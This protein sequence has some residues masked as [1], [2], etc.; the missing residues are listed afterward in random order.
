[1]RQCVL[2][3]ILALALPAQA[4]PEGPGWQ[5]RMA[6]MDRDG[7]D[8]TSAAGAFLCGHFAMSEGD[9]AFAA[10]RFRVA[11]KA[12]PANQGIAEQALVAS[13]LA[14][15]PSADPLA[16]RIVRV[17]SGDPLARLVL[18]GSAASR[19]NWAEAAHH[20][21]A[22]SQQSV[23]AAMQPALLAWAQFGAGRKDALRALVRPRRDGDTPGGAYLYQAG[24]MADLAGRQ[25]E[26]ELLY[27]QAQADLGPDDLDLAQA[28]ASLQA[29]QGRQDDALQTLAPALAGHHGSGADLR[30]SASRLRTGIASRPVRNPADAIAGVYVSF[31]RLAREQA[32][33]E[34][35]DLLLSLALTLRPDLTIARLHAA[36][37]R[38]A[39]GHRRAALAILAP[40]DPGDPLAPSVE[41]ERAKL[42]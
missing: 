2:C 22:M 24:L 9:F 3:L 20:F 17:A 7:G 26:A 34:V 41:Q 28:L 36:E 23:F 27:R 5:R 31:A 16:Q 39:A 15:Q 14:D 42:R 13:V 6:R 18:G 10:D 37:D 8:F 1:M 19:G 25:Q 29:R 21:A 12:A 32:A 38:Y 11:L 40:V 30:P 4:A 35:S 33:P